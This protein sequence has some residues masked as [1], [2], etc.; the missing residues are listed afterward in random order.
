MTKEVQ[1]EWCAL[2]LRRLTAVEKEEDRGQNREGQRPAEEHAERRHDP[3]LEEA[4]KLGQHQCCVRRG[5]T[6]GGDPGAA[7]NTRD[8]ALHGLERAYAG[9]AVFLV[10]RH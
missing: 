1:T 3:E 8:G 6:D 9:R 2:F 10:A 5:R 4:A 7:R